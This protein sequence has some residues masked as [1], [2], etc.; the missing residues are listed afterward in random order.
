MTETCNKFFSNYCNKISNGV[1]QTKYVL[2]IYFTIQ[3]SKNFKCEMSPIHSSRNIET[4][5]RL[6]IKLD[7]EVILVSRQ[8]LNIG[9]LNY[10][11]D[12]AF[13]N[14]VF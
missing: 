7:R 10:L 9:Y 13:G 12:V 5:R 4:R 8:T 6:N 2:F 1:L 11:F 3:L 14:A